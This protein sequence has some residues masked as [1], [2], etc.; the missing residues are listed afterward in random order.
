MPTGSTS[1]W[2][3]TRNDNCNWSSQFRNWAEIEAAYN[4]YDSGDLMGCGGH[5]SKYPTSIKSYYDSINVL[6]V[7]KGQ[8]DE[9]VSGGL[10]P[11]ATPPP[12]STPS[13]LSPPPVPPDQ[14]K[15]SFIVTANHQGSSKDPPCPDEF[16]FWVTCKLQ[17]ETRR[18]GLGLATAIAI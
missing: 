8:Y 2:S 17:T 14:S 6:S 9:L 4:S 12:P 7:M 18:G 15:L 1:G 11:I 13:S 10:V 3:G 5:Q 16:P